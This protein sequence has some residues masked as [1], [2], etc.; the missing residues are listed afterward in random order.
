MADTAPIADQS[1]SQDRSD[2]RQRFPRHQVI[3]GAKLRD[4]QGTV[5]CDVL[6]LSAGGA[7]VR[8]SVPF[9]A[10]AEV[11]LDIAELHCFHATVAWS[12]GDYLGLEFHDEPEGV[13]AA[14]PAILEAARDERERRRYLRSSVIWT[15]EIYGG[16][17]R[18][19]CEVLNVS[20][21]GAKLRTK[22]HF[23]IG[24]QI[25]IR[26]IRFGEFQAEV[27]WQ[28]KE[29]NLIGISFPENQRVMQL[30]QKGAH[31]THEHDD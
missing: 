10:G 5:D 16:L 28:D 23:P 21:A 22:G 17:R 14:M 29:A 25:T 9:P 19:K 1:G 4:S 18:A 7:K 31:S 2:E 27:V 20:S 26:S 12:Q 8:A 6:D 15:G 24:T 11:R 30:L 13:A 3:V